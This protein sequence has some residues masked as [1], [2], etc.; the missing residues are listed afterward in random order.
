MLADTERATTMP[1]RRRRAAAVAV[2][3]GMTMASMLAIAVQPT[4]S[5]ALGVDD[6]LLS[7]WGSSISN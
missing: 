4:L 5:A 1:L 7:Q 6:V 2:L 3:A